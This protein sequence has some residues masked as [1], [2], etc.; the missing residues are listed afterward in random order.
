MDWTTVG[1]LVGFTLV[2]SVSGIFGALRDW[3]LGFVVPVNPL[4][5]L[6][7]FLDSTLAVGFCVGLGWALLGKQHAQSAVL[8]GGLVAIAS[9]SADEALALVHGIVRRVLP[10]RTSMPPQQ[11]VAPRVEPKKKDPSM[12]TEAEAH[13]E[14]DRKEEQEL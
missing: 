11:L 14:L 7:T 2:I 3:L 1:G 4:R 6:G 10:F 5:V 12:L 9:A 13:A 8:M